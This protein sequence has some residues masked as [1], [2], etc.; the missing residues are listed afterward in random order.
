MSSCCRNLYACH[1][2]PSSIQV[3]AEPRPASS[4]KM[5]RYRA[6]SASDIMGPASAVVPAEQA[7]LHQTKRPCRTPDCKAIM[8]HSCYSIS[9]FAARL[10]AML[11]WTRLKSDSVTPVHAVRGSPRSLSTQR[12]LHGHPQD[13]AMLHALAGVAALCPTKAPYA[14]HQLHLSVIKSRTALA[15][16]RGLQYLALSRAREDSAQACSDAWALPDGAAHHC[17][18]Q[19]WAGCCGWRAPLQSIGHGLRAWIQNMQNYSSC[20]IRHSMQLVAGT[21]IAALQTER[22]FC[23]ARPSDSCHGACKSRIA[24]C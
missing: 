20:R 14:R 22:K 5:S 21:A 23:C 11:H 19:L 8:L 17:A 16:I 2:A 10:T 13:W 15:A 24:S 4:P 6:A 7:I 18:D 3:P 9:A 12:S 1:N